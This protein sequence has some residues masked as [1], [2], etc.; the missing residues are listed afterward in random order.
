MTFLTLRNAWLAR[1]Y[2]VIWRI[3]VIE[4][5]KMFKPF[6]LVDY[7]TWVRVIDVYDGDT[8]KVLMH[9][10]GYIDQWTIRMNGYDSPE[11]KPAKSNPNRDKEKEADKKT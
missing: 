8:I 9:Y 2:S 6:N 4:N 5:K 10:R 11:I 1:K 3:K 7:C